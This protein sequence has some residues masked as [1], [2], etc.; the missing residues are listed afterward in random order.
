MNNTDLKLMKELQKNGAISYSE[1]STILGVTP[2]TVGKRVEKLIQ[3]RIISVRAQP[4][5]YKLGLSACAIVAI[6]A[7]ATAV[8][9]ICDH[10]TGFFHV[11]LVQ[12]FFGR[13]DIMAIVYFPDFEMLHQF[14]DDELYTI[15]GVT[16]LELFF[17]HEIF[18]RYERFFKKEPFQ[19]EP[20]KLSQN[21]WELISEL[22]KDGRL[23]PS[24]L[25]EKL[26][27]H[28]T[29]VYRRIS[30]LTEGDIIKIS[31]VPNPL[32]FAYSASAYIMLDVNPNSVQGIC[33]TLLPYKEV[34]F[35]MTLGKRSG[36]IICVHSTDTA[37]LHQFLQKVV[38]PLDG[39]I[40]T[41][42]LIGASV[43]KT[44]YGWLIG[45]G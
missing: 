28:V 42:T 6:K 33:T 24:V 15:E 12:V 4:N 21:D 1:L 2:K 25:A 35:V 10:L 9:G 19:K 39:I 43:K 37:S 36:M 14:I 45:I 29:T 23:N 8:E 16:Q 17:V 30:A 11:N 32:K 40:D 13:F 26:G 27:I 34:H 5:P 7:N 38:I 41:E 20:V 3:S 18:K 22:S 31:G 44:Y